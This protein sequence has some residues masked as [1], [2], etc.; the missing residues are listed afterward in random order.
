[1]SNNKKET[2]PIVVECNVYKD[3][4]WAD[5]LNIYHCGI[6]GVHFKLRK[7]VDYEDSLDEEPILCPV[8]EVENELHLLE[9]K[10]EDS[11]NEC[12]DYRKKLEL[13]TSTST[14]DAEVEMFEYTT[15]DSYTITDSHAECDEDW[16][17]RIDIMLIDQ[18]DCA[19]K[20]TMNH[21][22]YINK[23]KKMDFDPLRPYILT[24]FAEMVNSIMGIHSYFI[25]R[26][27]KYVITDEHFEKLIT[28]T[29][30]SELNSTIHDEMKR[31]VESCFEKHL[32]SFSLSMKMISSDIKITRT[33][34]TKQ[35][36]QLIDAL[37]D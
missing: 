23:I 12:N 9:G 34:L 14:Q 19:I 37:K 30:I 13:E 7:E 26:F 35:V 16:I 11:L 17:F 10:Y 24:E 1:M 3:R 28:N 32:K 5:Q 33:T 18:S 15:I 29:Y 2:Q 20:S 4:T 31:Y 21:I 36:I 6:H 25:N 22:A 27:S 8:G